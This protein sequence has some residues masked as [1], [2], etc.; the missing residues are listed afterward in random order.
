MDESLRKFRRADMVDVLQRIAG[1]LKII[2]AHFNNQ[3]LESKV[4]MAFLKIVQDTRKKD[5][6]R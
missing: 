3:D 5:V 1:N 4:C 2:A 6:F